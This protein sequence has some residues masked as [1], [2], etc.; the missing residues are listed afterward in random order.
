[1]T[2]WT[3][4][5]LSPSL[6]VKLKRISQDFLRQRTLHSTLVVHFSSA[7]LHHNRP[8]RGLLGLQLVC[9]A[10]TST[11]VARHQRPEARTRQLRCFVVVV[12]FFRRPLRLAAVITDVVRILRQLLLFVFLHTT[13]D[14]ERTVYHADS[15]THSSSLPLPILAWDITVRPT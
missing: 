12:R 13:P 6:L 10:A 15:E 8:F 2:G 5:V 14:T 11:S 1:M 3:V 4:C 7:R 9:V